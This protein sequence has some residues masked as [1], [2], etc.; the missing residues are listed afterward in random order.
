VLP[1]FIFD[2][3]F[4][5]LPAGHPAAVLRIPYGTNKVL[6]RLMLNASSAVDPDARLD[7]DHPAF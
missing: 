6:N 4:D 5:V 7:Y 1:L 3:R 2:T